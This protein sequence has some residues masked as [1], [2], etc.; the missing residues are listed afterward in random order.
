MANDHETL[1]ALDRMPGAEV[2]CLDGSAGQLEMLGVRPHSDQVTHL[3]VRRGFLFQRDLMVPMDLI[4]HVE[5]EN[6]VISLKAPLSAVVSM[7]EYHPRRPGWLEV[8]FTLATLPVRLPFAIALS[9]W[10]QNRRDIQARIMQAAK[11][12][13]AKDLL[14]HHVFDQSVTEPPTSLN[15]NTATLEQLMQ[16]RGIGHSLAEQIIAH[17]PFQSMDDLRTIPSLSPHTLHRLGE[18]AVF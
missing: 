2:V 8:G 15:L 18:V 12:A 14:E 6:N 5:P 16:V 17:R 10:R 3:I 13:R 7:P 1:A 9:L 4:D 11:K